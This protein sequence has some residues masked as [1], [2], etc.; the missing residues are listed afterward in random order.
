MIVEVEEKRKDVV[1]EQFDIDKERFDKEIR[2]F[3]M[4]TNEPFRMDDDQSFAH[5]LAKNYE[6]YEYACR[7]KKWV[8]DA[9]DGG[10]FPNC[11]VTG[12]VTSCR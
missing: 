7:M 4:I 10:Y 1:F 5:N 2:G 3:L 12:T 6:L 8:G 9:V 11:S